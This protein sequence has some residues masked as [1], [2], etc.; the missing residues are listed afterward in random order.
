MRCGESTRRSGKKTVNTSPTGPFP[1]LF[2]LQRWPPLSSPARRE[3]RIKTSC[4]W[5]CRCPCSSTELQ[6][7]VATL[8]LVGGR[9]EGLQ[10]HELCMGWLHHVWGCWRNL[11][12]FRSHQGRQ[13]NAKSSYLFACWNPQSIALQSRSFPPPT[14]GPK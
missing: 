14:P 9:D 5:G 10:P 3:V 12:F 13:L 6:V 7:F 11:G 2:P 4:L 8:V 1:S